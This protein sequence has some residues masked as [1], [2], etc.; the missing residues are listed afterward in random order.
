MG[1][2]LF[3]PA[4]HR[5]IDRR[6]GGGERH[7][8]CSECGYDL[9][10]LSPEANCPECGTPV[11]T[12]LRTSLLAADA[13]YLM[14]LRRISRRLAWLPLVW[15]AMIAGAVAI[16]VAEIAQLLGLLILL[17]LV[18]GI[19]ASWYPLLVHD[20]VQLE[21]SDCEL[22]RRSH[23]T[24]IV[25]FLVFFVAALLGFSNMK[26]GGI[27]LPMSIAPVVGLGSGIGLASSVRRLA[28]RAGC[29]GPVR[30]A[31]WTFRI[32]QLAAWAFMVS[33]LLT[34]IRLYLGGPWEWWVRILLWST[35]G[36]AIPSLFIGNALCILLSFRTNRMLSR[37]LR[38]QSTAGIG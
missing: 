23:R 4:E 20:F 31:A 19:A 37:L 29:P 18:M 3:D 14:Q 25:V 8:P 16:L 35:V 7:L 2:P 9:C 28:R 30:L 11:G 5:T 10:G 1:K 26:H 24:S 36:I 38:L 21:R 22:I 32:T 27:L 13:A 33:L 12:T 6:D 17:L 34:G 15:A